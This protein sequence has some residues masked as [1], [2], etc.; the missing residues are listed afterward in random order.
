[1]RVLF[2]TLRRY[3]PE[4]VSGAKFCTDTLLTDLVQR[5]HPCELVAA[6]EPGFRGRLERSRAILAGR[7]RPLNGSYQVRRAPEAR[8][9]DLFGKTTHGASPTGD[10]KLALRRRPGP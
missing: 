2:A 4:S 1:M 7:F 3:L 6:R 5:G 8:V 10:R 9:L